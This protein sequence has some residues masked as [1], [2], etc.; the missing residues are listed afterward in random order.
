MGDPIF[1]K[2][3]CDDLVEAFAASCSR[4]ARE[5]LLEDETLVKL[6][7]LDDEY[8]SRGQAILDDAERKDA[9]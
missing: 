8:L 1:K 3:I 9:D 6:S 7:E 5:G 2:I 4:L